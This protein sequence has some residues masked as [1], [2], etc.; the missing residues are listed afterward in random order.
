MKTAIIIIISLHAL[1]HLMGFVKAYKPEAIEQLKKTISKST[2]IVWLVTCII[3]IL[4]LGLLLFGNPGWWMLGIVS[5][6]LS[7]VLIYISWED[8]KYG[9]IFNVLYLGY[10]AFL[11]YE[12]IFIR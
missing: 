5:V 3:M 8:A 2:G 12:N 4:S 6:I 9:T 1:I 7:Q 10:I 11:V